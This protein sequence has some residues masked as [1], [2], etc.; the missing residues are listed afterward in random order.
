MEFHR[1]ASYQQKATWYSP[2][3]KSLHL[4]FNDLMMFENPAI[5]ADVSLAE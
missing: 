2:A 4:P 1:I 5:R 3:A